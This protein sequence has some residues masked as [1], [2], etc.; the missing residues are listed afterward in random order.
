MI[1][2]VA[3]GKSF[4]SPIPMWYPLVTSTTKPIPL[5]TDPLLLYAI[6]IA[7]ENIQHAMIDCS[8]RAGDKQ[9]SIKHTK[10]KMGTVTYPE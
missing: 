3:N 10:S 7:V 9:R 5:V 2:I 1:Y 6:N 4:P 8:I